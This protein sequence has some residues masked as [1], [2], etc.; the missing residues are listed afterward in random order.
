MYIPIQFILK[1]EN[2]I[3]LAGKISEKQTSS[4]LQIG[5]DLSCMISLRTVA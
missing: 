4:S 3:I 5:S 1:L 2:S